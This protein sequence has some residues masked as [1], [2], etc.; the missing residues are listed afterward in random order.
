MKKNN[1]FK[2]AFAIICATSIC[3]NMNCVLA[4]A[5]TD[6]QDK[7]N[8]INNQIKENQYQQSSVQSEAQAYISQIAALD[9]QI[10]EYE[11]KLSTLKTS[12]EDINTKIEGFQSELQNSAQLFNS[13]EDVYLTRVRAIYENGIPSVFEILVSSNGIS[14]FFSKLGV[15][16]S[17]LEY[18]QNIIDNMKSQK[19]YV[20]YLKAEIDDAKLSLEAISYDVEKSTEALEN[21]RAQKQTKVSELQASAS[22]LKQVENELNEE[23]AAANSALAAAI[24]AARPK[25]GG[26]GNNTYTSTTFIWPTTSSYITAG[27]GTYYVWGFAQQHNGVDVGVGIGTPVYAAA[28]GTVIIATVVTSNP[29]GYGG[30]SKTS[31]SAANGYGYGNYI[32]IEH[33]D[34]KITI[35]GHLS[36]VAVNVGQV[37]VQ[38]QVIGYSGSTGNSSGPHLHFEVRLGSTP[39]NPMSYFN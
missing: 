37:V 14:D 4:D 23:K 35:Y 22:K 28:T 30:P 10:S 17:I 21:V 31:W 1:V 39:V 19:E 3:L 16:T 33:P 27:F 5:I 11:T 29:Y 18:D 12:Q 34:G 7:V 38:G 36:S 15:Y 26:G 25:Y 24:E 32:A 20:D 9:T 2:R 6:A 8:N 13:A